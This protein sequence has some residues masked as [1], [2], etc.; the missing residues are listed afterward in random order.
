MI[1]EGTQFCSECGTRIE[2]PKS[3]PKCAYCGA[4]LKAT[5]KFCPKCGR[6]VATA[7][8]TTYRPVPTPAKQIPPQK[9]KKIKPL[10]VIIPVIAVVLSASILVTGLVVPGWMKPSNG[11]NSG[12]TD[13]GESPF[14]GSGKMDDVTPEQIS[15]MSD[16]EF[17][18]YLNT[19][20]PFGEST[21]VPSGDQ[22]VVTTVSNDN[23][24]VRT[25]SGV[26]V[27]LTDYIL[28]AGETAQLSVVNSGTL[29]AVNDEWQI[30]VYDITLGDRHELYDFVTIRLSYDDS[31]AEAGQRAE[32][33]VGV[34]CYNIATKCW[35]PVL[36]SVDTARHELI[37]ET[38][39]FSSYGVVTIKNIGL[40]NTYLTEATATSGGPVSLEVAQY[41]LQKFAQNDDSSM[42]VVGAAI[43][44][45]VIEYSNDM[46]NLSSAAGLIDAL[47]LGA[48]GEELLSSLSAIKSVNESAIGTFLN[49]RIYSGSLSSMAGKCFTKLGQA[50]TLVKL[51]SQLINRITTGQELSAEE[52]YGVWK[53]IAFF[54]ASFSTGAV[55]PIF[56]GA[57]WAL[58][59]CLNWMKSEAVDARRST[60]ADL[61]YYYNEKYTGTSLSGGSNRP[62]R[63]VKDWRQWIINFIE[64]PQ[65]KNILTT[66]DGLQKAL[67]DEIE[68]YAGDFWK[69]GP[70]DIQSL[71]KDAGMPASLSDA[72]AQEIE[73]ITKE[74]IKDLYRHL[75]PV[76]TSVSVYCYKKAEKELAQSEQAVRNFY[77]EAIYVNVIE[78]PEYNEDDEAE[79]LYAGCKAMFGD[80]NDVAKKED[81]VF[82]LDENGYAN[83]HFSLISHLL[84]GSPDKIYIYEKD[85]DPIK[86]TDA[87][88]I[89]TATFTVT[90]GFSAY[91]YLKHAE[92][93][94][95]TIPW[96]GSFFGTTIP[97]PDGRDM[98]CEYTIKEDSYHEGHYNI[99]VRIDGFTW[100]EFVAYCKKIQALPG[101]QVWS[102]E[103]VEH[104][105]DQPYENGIVY[106]T[107]AYGNIKRLNLRFNGPKYVESKVI[108]S[109]S[110]FAFDD[111]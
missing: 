77:N 50:A 49:K 108:P 91:A 12:G 4:E 103:D 23:L 93:S 71:A 55:V 24:T 11:G 28:V 48:A 17:D 36:Y 101:W 13:Y 2:S 66:E 25:Q 81:W 31:F 65:N 5:S 58:D 34:R 1:P 94:A 89:A 70:A 33:C 8:V 85:V 67:K 6:S 38:D 95:N 29:T 32:D 53:D 30:E 99:T 27:E 39:H 16:E 59:Y 54:A 61:Y 73:K 109:F 9:A 63:S 105:P 69:L 106:F 57:C 75:Y 21:W 100:E 111:F 14:S 72:S 64:D 60:Y 10:A 47:K 78:E 15:N 22:P 88:P 80:L 51:T 37:V 87:K 52:F 20:T 83:E 26:S 96:D 42:K 82:T 84:V 97:A 92:D 74:Y 56:A 102:N 110:I 46:M 68:S 19:L 79:Y 107:G 98:V 76:M 45:E 35:E 43:F 18:A 40:R 3:A 86:D 41:A 44:G 62:G 90:E 7:P 104:F